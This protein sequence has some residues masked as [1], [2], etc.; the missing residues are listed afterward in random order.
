MGKIKKLFN[1]EGVRYIIFGVLTTFV[2][3]FSYL[4]L[5]KIGITYIVSN[6]IAFILSIIFAFITNKMYVFGS[7]DLDI[8]TIIKEG[9]TFLFSRLATFVM[10]TALMVL[11]IEI[12]LMSDFIAKCIVNVIVIIVNYILSRYIVFN[13]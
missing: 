7:K 5:N 6:T 10:D 1:S 4:V 13:K 11:F 2:N 9:I 8:K 3:I 12:I